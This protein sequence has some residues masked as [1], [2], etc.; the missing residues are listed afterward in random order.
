MAS[1]PQQQVAL[2]TGASSGIGYELAQCFACDGHPLIVVAEDEQGINRAAE[3]LRM[4]GARRVEPV[5][6]DLAR[7]DGA[8]KLYEAVTQLGLEPE[9]LVLNAGVG[10][11]ATSC[12]RPTSR[13]A[14]D[15]PAQR[16]V[17]GPRR[18]AVRARD[19]AARLWQNPHHRV[20]GRDRAVGQAR[21]LLGDQGL[22]PHDCRGDRRGIVGH[23]SRCDGA[24]ARRHRDPF[25]RACGRRRE[26]DRARQEGRSRGRRRRRLP[27]HA[28]GQRPC[29]RAGQEQDRRRGREGAPER[30]VAHHTRAD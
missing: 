28:Q 14:A 29:G 1:Q 13:R 16:G 27:G 20:A 11:C 17:G 6:V 25:L 9:F 12:A 26:P 2:V 15:D 21:R 5:T 22:R 19:G 10:V 4:A 7:T 23:R 30:F 8:P 18:Q 3:G 24:N